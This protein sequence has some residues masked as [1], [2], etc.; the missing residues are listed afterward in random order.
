MSVT[1][2]KYSGFFWHRICHLEKNVTS[3]SKQYTSSGVDFY[4]R[5]T[6]YHT[7]SYR[8]GQLAAD[9]RL[10][11]YTEATILCILIY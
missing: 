7:Q 5:M 10:A 11:F 6:Q 8:P 9:S 3:F 2:Q 1:Y 4:A